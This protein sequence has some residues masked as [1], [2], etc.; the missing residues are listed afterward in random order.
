MSAHNMLRLTE[1]SNYTNGRDWD[2]AADIWRTTVGEATFASLTGALAIMGERINQTPAAIGLGS[3]AAGLLVAT[4]H[5]LGRLHEMSHSALVPEETSGSSW[6]DDL[7]E[8]R[9]EETAHSLIE[10]PEDP[11][12]VYTH[13]KRAEANRYLAKYGLART[14]LIRSSEVSFG[15]HSYEGVPAD[16][17]P[18][19]A[20]PIEP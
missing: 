13:R 19:P 6:T 20:D 10:P 4:G 9:G 3:L 5:G 12:A 11:H 15:A 7:S 2:R 1:R 18:R 16:Q 17:L 8:P 14:R